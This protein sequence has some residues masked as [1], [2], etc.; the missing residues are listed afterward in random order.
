MYIG[1]FKKLE[2]YDDKISSRGTANGNLIGVAKTRS[3]EY[4]SGILCCKFCVCL[5][6]AVNRLVYNFFNS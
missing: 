6:F 5:C 4:H 1:S 2:L 3:I